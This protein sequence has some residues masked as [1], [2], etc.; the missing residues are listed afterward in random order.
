MTPTDSQPIYLL[1]FDHRGSFQK[2]LLGI[3]G[4]PTPDE[5]AKIRAPMLIQHASNDEW[6]NSGW[7]AFEAALK[8][9]K[10]KY[11]EYTYPNTEHGFNNDTT[12]RYSEAQAKIAWQRTVD[13][14]NKHVRAS[15]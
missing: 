12:P 4:E 14:F 9:N 6:V 5:V 13:W 1:A 8:K 15:S 10:V 7:P 2:K 3:Q 11:E